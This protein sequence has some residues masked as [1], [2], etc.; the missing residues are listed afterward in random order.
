MGQKGKS[1]RR[2][3]DSGRE[4]SSAD[5]NHKQ[6]PEQGQGRGQS[7]DE[8]ADTW[9]LLSHTYLKLERAIA[10]QLA[11]W[12][13]TPAQFDVLVWLAAEAG[14]SQQELAER[15]MVT[16]GNVSQLVSRL[17]SRG[18]IQRLRDGRVLRLQL[19][20]EGRRLHEQVVPAYESWIPEHFAAL[21]SGQLRRLQKALR[22][23][24]QQF[25]PE[26]E[27]NGPGK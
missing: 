20:D 3:S 22:L 15:L 14:I 11:A 19:T 18:L 13:L 23:L 25:M 8:V 17:E 12:E 6:L 21:K 4:Q 5:S 1:K 26:P 10:G 9:A 27:A 7:N 16:K 24:D 2:R